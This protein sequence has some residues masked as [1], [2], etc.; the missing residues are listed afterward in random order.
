MR[1][2]KFHNLYILSYIFSVPKEKEER[3]TGEYRSTYE[4][5][6]MLK[7]ILIL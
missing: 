5:S 3:P 1:N 6:V 7:S 2:E 4:D